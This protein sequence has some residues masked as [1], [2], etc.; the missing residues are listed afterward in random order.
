MLKTNDTN[1]TKLHMKIARLAHNPLKNIP[2]TFNKL[3]KTLTLKTTHPNTMTKLKSIL[4][5]KSNTNKDHA[6]TTKMLKP[7]YLKQTT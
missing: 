5:N 7:I 1:P 2:Q 3:S 4:N 6:H